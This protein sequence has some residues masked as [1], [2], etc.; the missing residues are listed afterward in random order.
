M[1]S[2]SSGSDE[3]ADAA[4][5]HVPDPV[6]PACDLGA[7]RAH[8]GRRPQHVLALQQARDA[9]LPDREG[10]EHQR[11]MADRLVARHADAAGKRAGRRGATSAGGRW[12]ACM[13]VLEAGR[14]L[15]RDGIV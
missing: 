12:L 7:E 1:S 3:P 15:A 11:A 10:A 13:A 6:R 2:T 5:R 14:R 4:A 8:G 9:G